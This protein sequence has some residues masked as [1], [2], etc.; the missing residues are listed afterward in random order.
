MKPPFRADHVGSLLRPEGLAKARKQ[1]DFEFQQQ[2][3]RAVV[4]RQEAI[5]LQGV[6]D[7]ELSRDWWHLDFLS[8]L[9]GVAL[10][11]NP[12]PKFGNH[13]DRRLVLGA[14]ELRPRVLA[15]RDAFELG[16]E[17]EMHLRA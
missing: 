2:A 5:G 15:Q 17:V 3:I 13:R 4:A 7:G 16:Q 10:R 9:E 11:E 14:A 8:Q 6:T 12:G 1:K